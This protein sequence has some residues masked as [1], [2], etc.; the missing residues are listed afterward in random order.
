MNVR[1]WSAA[2][3]VMAL[4]VVGPAGGGAVWANGIDLPQRSGSPGEQVT[5][6]GHFWLTCCPPNTPVEHVRLYMIIDEE[7]FQL[8][9][10]AADNDGNMKASFTVPD[11]PAG[12]YELEACGDDP[13]GDRICLPE[14]EFIVLLAGTGTAGVFVIVGIAVLLTVIVV[15]IIRQRRRAV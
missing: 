7:R 4:V 12:S 13:Q 1:R 8:F 14:G 6:T 11:I 3:C 5:V 10:V 2:I 9:D 15:L